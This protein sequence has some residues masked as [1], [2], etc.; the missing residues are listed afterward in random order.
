MGAL[1]GIVNGAHWKEA[2]VVVQTR[3]CLS[4]RGLGSLMVPDS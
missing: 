4:A 2:G 1:G 3:I